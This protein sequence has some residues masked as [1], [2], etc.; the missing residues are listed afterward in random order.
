MVVLAA[1]LVLHNL[2]TDFPKSWHINTYTNILKFYIYKCKIWSHQTVHKIYW[3]MMMLEMRKYFWLCY[4][5]WSVFL[6]FK[7]KRRIRIFREHFYA[8]CTSKNQ[9]QYFFVVAEF[10]VE[11]IYSQRTCFV[12][13]SIV[14]RFVPSKFLFYYD[15][16]IH[17]IFK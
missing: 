16:I 8:Y 10:G 6:K 13:V 15:C 17:Y 9:I 7:G 12:C 14:R 1:L 4:T 11:Y 5:P 2:P 3:K